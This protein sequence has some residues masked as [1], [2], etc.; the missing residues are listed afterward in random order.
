MSSLAIAL[1]TDY[2]HPLPVLVC[3]P[4]GT[5]K[6]SLVHELARLRSS[7]ASEVSDGSEGRPSPEDKLLE[8]HVDEETD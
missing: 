2:P 8:L 6:S 4:P 7:V 5:G 3:G 1:C